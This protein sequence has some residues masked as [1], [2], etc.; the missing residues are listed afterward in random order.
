M[1]SK[2][3]RIQLT[4]AA[5]L[6]AAAGWWIVD[7]YAPARLP[8]VSQ[9]PLTAPAEPALASS[10][11]LQSNSVGQPVSAPRTAAPASGKHEVVASIAAMHREFEAASDWRAF[12]HAAR[13]K[14]QSGGYFYAMRA[15]EMCSRNIALLDS[16]GRENLTKEIHASG[17]TSIRAMEL[18]DRL[19]SRCSGFAN[20]EAS[21][22][23]AQTIE[24]ARD[25]KDPLVVARDRVAKATTGADWAAVRHAASDLLA[26][27]DKTAMT[28]DLM[29]IRLMRF[30]PRD[31]TASSFWFAGE[32]V[33]QDRIGDFQ[34]AYQLSICKRDEP[35]ES[36]ELLALS[37]TSPSGCET[38]P[39]RF[40]RDQYLAGGGSANG[41]DQVL[42]LAQRMHAAMEAGSVDAF[43]RSQ[44]Q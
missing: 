28:Q 24:L 39:V 15:A 6:V 32:E 8:A 21:S 30:G 40:Y 18:A 29:L 17:T 7:S 38:D 10:G 14:P 13:A 23:N 42:A 1:A 12:A 44:A 34:L 9:A 43:V 26:L 20:G 3:S 33:P 27:G 35:C 11:V 31:G 41:F 22:F 5:L 2:R 4:A 37:C 36:N 16:F 25:N 19:R